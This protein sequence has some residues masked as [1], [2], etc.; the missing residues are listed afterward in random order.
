MDE[1]RDHEPRQSARSLFSNPIPLG[2]LRRER[3]SDEEL[4]SAL[5]RAAV[6]AS[7][8]VGYVNLT[9]EQILDR[10]GTSRTLFYRVF[11][12]RD[13][14]YASGYRELGDT[15]AAH[16][17]EG[18]RAARDWRAGLAGALGALAEF[19]A[20][21]PALANGLIVQVRAAGAGALRVHE[22]IS[23]PLIAALDRAREEAPG[24]SPPASAGSFIFAAIESAA[25]QAL[26]RNAPEEFA[27]KVPDLAFLASATYFGEP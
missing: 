24:P 11:P 18:C 27:V 15:L 7:G 23:A 13:H 17:L 20:A 25:I 6:E 4:R 22:A 8:E 10:A 2:D 14:C 12:D 26:S 9:V 5:G 21:Q 3:V 1:P 19:M 16:L